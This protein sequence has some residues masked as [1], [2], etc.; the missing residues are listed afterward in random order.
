MITRWVACFSAVGPPRMRRSSSAGSRF[1][2]SMVVNADAAV[3]IRRYTQ[4]CQ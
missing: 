4:P 3:K 1:S 2:S